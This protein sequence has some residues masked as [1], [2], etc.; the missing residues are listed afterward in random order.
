MN[1]P[2]LERSRTGLIL[3]RLPLLAAAVLFLV[4][5]RLP[6]IE[7]KGFDTFSLTSVA[8]WATRAARFTLGAGLLCLLIRPMEISRWWMAL[9]VGILLGP[10]ADMAIRSADLVEMMGTD[11]P[12]DP[13]EMIVLQSG[14]WA[15]VAGLG[16][17]VLDVVVALALRIVPWF[18]GR[19][20]GR[21]PR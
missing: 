3:E 5:T 9:S 7:I 19:K 2:S 16:F 4:A 14:T 15:C 1:P 6:I 11:G 21:S 18:R 8:M 17:W 20:A 12:A 13:G 10:L